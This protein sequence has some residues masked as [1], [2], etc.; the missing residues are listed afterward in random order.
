MPV[1]GCCCGCSIFLGSVLVLLSRLIKKTLTET[2]GIDFIWGAF[3]KS[4]QS[5]WGNNLRRPLA[6]SGKWS[7]TFP[8]SDAS[9]SKWEMSTFIAA[10]YINQ[11][12][13][14]F[15][16]WKSLFFKAVLWNRSMIINSV[17]IFSIKRLLIYWLSEAD[18][19]IFFISSWFIDSGSF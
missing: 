14:K 1:F 6:G 9:K 15:S 12:A 4:H 18:L 10:H 17:V 8:E 2:G 19:Q 5:T 16:E 7:E 3:R 11:T 13:H